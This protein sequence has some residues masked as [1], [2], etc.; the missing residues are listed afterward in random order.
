MMRTKPRK[1][2]HFPSRL[3]SDRKEM[4]LNRTDAEAFFDALA[5]PPT[6]TSELAA[7]LK[8]HERRVSWE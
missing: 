6:I 3:T 7:A 2:P 5:H 1:Q 8:E 4:I